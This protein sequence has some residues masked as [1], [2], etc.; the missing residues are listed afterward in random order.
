M[1]FFR[2]G[3]EAASLLS[4][5]ALANACFTS[6][7]FPSSLE[8]EA[9]SA[10]KQV[11]EGKRSLTELAG[12]SLVDRLMARLTGR[13]KEILQRETPQRVD[14]AQRRNVRV[15]YEAGKT[16]WIESRLQDFFGMTSLPAICRG[17]VR[18]TAHLLAPNGRAVQI[19]Q[20]LA[21]FWERHYPSIR[22]ELR[23]RYPRHAWPE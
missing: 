1:E 15:H 22:R 13:Q 21:G 5:I 16:P 6:E 18:L 20:D 4:R 8:S 19:T 11:C 23:R 7:G 3:K 9:G 2:D 10:V 17:Q 12:V 14:L